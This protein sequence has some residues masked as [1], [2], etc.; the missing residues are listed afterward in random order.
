VKLNLFYVFFSPENQDGYSCLQPS[1]FD[2]STLGCCIHLDMKSIG[3]T[4]I[5]INVYHRLF[6]STETANK[7]SR[8]KTIRI[9]GG[10]S[11]LLNI[12]VPIIS[13]IEKPSLIRF[14]FS[15]IDPEK[16]NCM[17]VSSIFS[18]RDRTPSST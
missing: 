10:K 3:K 18:I 14:H 13:S 2:V 11:T 7:S 12:S 1:V 6:K 4:S 5:L 9:Y 17:L 15:C 8:T 16:F